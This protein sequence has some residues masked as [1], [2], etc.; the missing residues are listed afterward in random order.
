VQNFAPFT[1]GSK[2]LQGKIEPVDAQQVYA[3]LDGVMQGVLTNRNADPAQLLDDAQKRVD[4]AL[5]T[6]Q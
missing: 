3:I 6:V 2:R 1:A 5:A 4:A